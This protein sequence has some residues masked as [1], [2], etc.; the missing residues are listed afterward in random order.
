MHLTVLAPLLIGAA[1]LG[2]FVW[3]ESRTRSPM[4]PLHLFRSAD[5]SGANAITLFLYFALSGALFF[6]PFNLISI[7][8][9]S[10]TAAGAAFLPFTLIMGL[11]S[12][13]SGGL[14]ER[15]GPRR[16]LIIGPL[17]VAV[18]FALLVVPGIGGSY[19]TTFFPSMIALG[20][21][22]AVSVAPLTTTVMRGADDRYA[23]VASGI[24]NATARV[25]GLLAVALLGSIAVGVFGRALDER[26][27]RLQPA[28]EVRSALRAEVPKLAEAKVPKGIARAEHEVLERAL[29]ESFVRSFRFVSLVAAALAALSATVAW[30]TID[31]KRK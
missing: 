30:L 3:L 12:R 6:V 31:R 14:I 11:L 23:G 19:W 15:Y 17:I 8:G 16:L 5:F 4:M 28:A 25:A 21:G 2:A 7:Q 20:F 22:M 29:H 24:N 18:G 9:Y 27:D 10:A 26:L 13:W 1:V